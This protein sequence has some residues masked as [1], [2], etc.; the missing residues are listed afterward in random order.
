[1]RAIGGFRKQLVN[2]T[3]VRGFILSAF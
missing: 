2:I 3:L 1:M